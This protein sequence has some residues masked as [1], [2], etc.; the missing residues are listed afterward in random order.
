MLLN[1]IG[2]FH[3]WK[4]LTLKQRHALLIYIVAPLAAMILQMFFYVLLLVAYGTLIGALAMFVFIL[5]EQ[6]DF[7]V[8]QVRENA[9]KEFDLKVLQMRPHF[10]YNA[11]L[12]I[13]YLVDADSQAA[14]QAILD[15]SKY[16]HQNFNAVVKTEQIPFQEELAHTKAYLAVEHARF[17]E[18][19]AVTYDTPHM[20]FRLPPLTLEP[21]VENAVKHGMDPDSEALHILIRTRAME[22]GSEITVEND[23]AEF[24]PAKP[25]GGV[26]LSSV[27]DRLAVMCGGTIMIAPKHGSGTIVTLW[28]PY[29]A[30]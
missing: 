17:G 24:K 25:G 11:M 23:G 15:F 21:I 16:L 28:I 7:A 5:T 4:K 27:R 26:S 6:M 30:K 14:K 18:R 12:S 19:L 1:L 20:M 29:S 10:I 22:S 3:R 13:Y 2:V 8:R 9:E